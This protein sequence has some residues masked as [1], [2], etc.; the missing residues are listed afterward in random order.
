MSVLRIFTKHDIGFARTTVAIR[1]SPSRADDQIINPIAIHIACTG[2]GRTNLILSIDAIDDKTVG[3]VSADADQSGKVKFVV[4]IESEC[5][6]VI[7][8]LAE[9]DIGFARIAFAVGISPWR[10][11]DQILNPITIDI[12][13]A[14]YRIS[15]FVT[16]ID[17]V[18]GKAVA[19]IKVGQLNHGAKGIHQDTII[20]GIRPA[21]HDIAL[22][23]AT[24]SIGISVWRA[25]DQ[26]IK[27]ITIHIAGAG[28]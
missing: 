19:A 13:C 2:Y 5:L 24:L 8:I 26:I 18:D 11:D 6:T 10:A 22:A 1:V 23:S 21:K 14:G 12:A 15:A 17:A 20:I 7:R 3:A 4:C 16:D 28:H 9:H 25:N 27:A